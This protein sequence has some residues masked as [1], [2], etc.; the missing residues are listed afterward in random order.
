MR[1]LL[2][3]SAAC[4]LFF[5][6]KIRGQ[7][8]TEN[9]DNITTLVAGGWFLQN[10][11]VPLGI[12]SW[13]Q[14]VN[15][16]ASGPFDSYNGAANAYI[17][18]NFNNT[19][20]GTGII[21]NWLLTPNRT[22][23]NGDV[24]TFFT[25]KAS[26]DTYPDRLEVRLSTNGAS[27]NTGSGT[28]VGDFTTLLMSINPTLTTGVYPT[29]WTQYTI[30]ISGLPAP[31][32]GRI[33]FRYFVT[34]AGPLGTNSDYIG[35]DNVVYTPY[36]CPTL[37]ISPAAGTFS[38]NAGMAYSQSFS[39]TG[40][41]GAPSYAVTAG[42]LPPGVTLSAGG[43]LSGTPTLAGTFPF[44]V[45]VSDASGCS[46][47][48]AY[49]LNVA[50]C[51]LDLSAALPDVTAACLVELT[52]LTV[53]NST[54]SCGNAIV[55]TT[56]PLIF[57]IT[58][59][60]ITTITWSYLDILG[61]IHTRTQNVVIEDTVDPVPS[62]AVLADI[63]AQC[64]VLEADVTVPSATDN[65]SGTVTVTHDATFPITAQGSTTI[66]WTYTDANGNSTT[67]TQN[68][69]I[70]DTTDPVPAL[71]VLADITGQCEVL[72][73]DVT[74][75][76]ATDNCSGTVTVTHDA[77]FPITAQGSTTITWTYTD[78]NGNTATQMQNV[79]INDITDPTVTLMDIAV[80][81]D[82]SGNA[83]ITGAQLDNGSA[84]NCGIDTIT[85]SPDTFD[86]DQ[87]GAHT[88]TVTVTDVNG[89]SATGTA[90]V[91]VNDDNSNCPLAVSQ[92]GKVSLSVYPNP[93]SDVVFI[94]T[95]NKEALQSVSV[96][97]LS[98]QQVFTASFV[99]AQQKYSIQLGQLSEGIY[100][101]KIESVNGTTVKRIAKQN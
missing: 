87:L 76:S 62:L 32:S 84:D 79:V 80:S 73:A 89:N 21:S 9:F 17:S 66:T 75:P 50:S 90:V 1:K 92:F 49:T 37:S 16:A 4:V 5:I 40:A 36:V 57:P 93:T 70:E 59:Q 7:A 29:A 3:L 26:P 95:S 47:S 74:A 67:Q 15:A 98:G 54:D 19:T 60:G 33:A 63:T 23:R 61:G 31:T 97:S 51:D 2:L 65:C 45:T 82:S 101:M 53:P 88:V 85:V 64:E 83:T 55:P 14:G 6:G 27:T 30:T 69:V 52:D 48:T 39:Q 13:S 81:I 99:Q 28:G 20:G 25:R 18:A 12:T 42:L 56:D 86:C 58:A 34:A 100:L 68:V 11:S 22:I 72:E 35:I 41:L 94:E 91:T 8:Y 46:G 44:T 10:S 77:T 24:F 43:T 71:A 96:Y 78:A 38:A